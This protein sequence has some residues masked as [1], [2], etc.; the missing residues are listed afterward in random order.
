MLI[1]VQEGL[2]RVMAGRNPYT[3]YNVP[4]PAPLA[5]GPLLWGPYALPMLMRADVRFVTAAGELFAPVACAI[6]ALIGASRGRLVAAASCLLVLAA[7]T[8]SPDL[9]QFAAIGH[10]PSYWP[11]LVLFAWL[12]ASERWKSAALLLGLLVTART[13]MVAMIPA[14]LIAVWLRD[15]QSIAGATALVIAGAV[16]PFLPFAILDM[17]ALTYALYGSYENVMK[18]F[19][20]TATTWVQHTIGVTGLLLSA[21]LE[22]WIEPLQVIALAAMYGACWV[23]MRRGRSPIVWLALSLL[24][25]SMTTL[26]P[27]SY[28]YI[29]V[30]VLLAAA[31]VV[32]AMPVVHVARTWAAAAAVTVALVLASA[33]VMLPWSLPVSSGVT[34]RNDPAVATAALTRRTTTPALID[35]ETGAPPA[36]G[37]ASQPMAATFN[38]A[39]VGTFGLPSD[40]GT[41]TLVVPSRLWIVGVNTLE[42]ALPAR[43]DIT[44]VTVRPPS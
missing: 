7:M 13:T 36:G 32:E 11:L 43:A 21:R 37:P 9:R 4:W 17:K 10:T 33:F 3:I 5:Y 12:V 44:R 30:L 41:V 35:V 6:G 2:K 39:A 26:W 15:R 29:D 19:V 40:H 20:W 18:T 42:L 22:R 34:W 28:I 27:V 8:F 16:L 31:V 24:V 14:L 23:A 25:F 38:G 1:V